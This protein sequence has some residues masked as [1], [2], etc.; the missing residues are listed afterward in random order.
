MFCNREL[1]ALGRMVVCSQRVGHRSGTVPTP[2]S[3]RVLIHKS[4]GSNRA[5]AARWYRVTWGPDSPI[6]VHTGSHPWPSICDELDEE[7][8]EDER[9][10]LT[11]H[12]YDPDL[13][14]R[15]PV[16]DVDGGRRE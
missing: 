1:P 9:E 6:H 11:E 8:E 4:R 14:Q 7:H 3:G 5:A 12:D 2:C 15:L 13:R 16:A 10:L